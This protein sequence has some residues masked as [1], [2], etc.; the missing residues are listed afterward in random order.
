MVQT[1]QGWVVTWTAYKFSLAGCSV[2]WWTQLSCRHI[3]HVCKHHLKSC[4]T[5]AALQLHRRNAIVHSI[6]YLRVSECPFPAT[7]TK[8]V[9]ASLKNLWS[10]WKQKFN[11]SRGRSTQA[12]LGHQLA[13]SASNM[14]HW[15]LTMRMGL[16]HKTLPLRRQSGSS[17]C[18]HSV[19]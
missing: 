16:A 9:A 8:R 1:V 17:T 4:A 12:M 7:C 14:M 6:A 5:L 2:R 11:R 15:V 19:P 10:R 18:S 3:H 13:P